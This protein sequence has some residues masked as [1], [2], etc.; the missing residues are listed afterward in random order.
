MRQLFLGIIILF[1]F[2]IFGCS[3]RSGE[4]GSQS[5]QTTLKFWHIMN[6]SGPKEVLERAVKRFESNHPDVKVQIQTFENDSYKVKLANEMASGN[7]PDVFFTWGAGGQTSEYIRQGKVECLDNY[8]KENDWEGK[9]IDSALSICR[10]EGKLYCLPLDLSAVTLWCNKDLFES[11][12]QSYPSTLDDLNRLVSVFRDKSITPLALGNMKKWPGAFY[13]CYLANRCGGTQLFL[14]AA[15]GSASFADES[16][17][18]AGRYLRDLI[19]LN[20]FSIG[21]NGL[22]DDVARVSFVNGKSA[23]YL[24]GTWLVARVKDENP[25]FMASM[26]PVPFPSV[27]SGKGDL[28]TVLGGVNC[29]FAVS[30]QSAHKDLAVELL[31]ALTDEQVIGEWCEI[32]RIPAVKTTPE[33][34]AKLPKPTQLALKL[35]DN[36]D[37]IQPYYDQFLPAKLGVQHANTTQNIFAGTMTPEEAAKAMAAAAEK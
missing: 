22:E 37:T 17:I 19:D 27:P 7:S 6:Y 14:D 9:F 4:G 32:G 8:S 25:D 3:R 36:A 18:L 35:L 11:H 23:M 10:L 29:G 16:F 20:A 30:S 34:V 13:F 2:V 21:F 15:S 26:V 5:S 28:R 33:Q 24:T 1:A 12:G 31:N